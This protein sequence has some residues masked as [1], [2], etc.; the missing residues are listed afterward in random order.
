MSVLND[1]TQWTE[2]EKFR[3]ERFLGG[4]GQLILKPDA[5]CQ[6]SM[7]KIYFLCVI[8]FIIWKTV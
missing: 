8:H 5:F 1:T 7:G 3:P 4:N 2:P 6:F